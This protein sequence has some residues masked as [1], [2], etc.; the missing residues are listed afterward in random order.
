MSEDYNR[1]EALI[2]KLYKL[3]IG[4]GNMGLKDEILI[5]KNNQENCPGRDI[6]VKID[7]IEREFIKIRKE[8][9]DLKMFNAKLLGGASALMTLLT[10]LTNLG[11]I[12]EYFK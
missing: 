2:E 7:V 6:N 11:R 8:I 4:N 10:I 1:L 5:L 9:S 3:I 12:L